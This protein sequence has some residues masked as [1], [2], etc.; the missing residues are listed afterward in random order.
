[1]LSPLTA[2]HYF[3]SVWLNIA[4]LYAGVYTRM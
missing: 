1:M 4:L 2:D 3:D